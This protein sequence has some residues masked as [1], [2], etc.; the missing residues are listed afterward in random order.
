MTANRLIL[1]RLAVAA[2]A[3]VAATQA[4]ASAQYRF[5][6]SPAKL[7]ANE[8]VDWA[9]FGPTGTVVPSG[10]TLLSSGGLDVEVDFSANRSGRRLFQGDGW[11]GNFESSEPVLW[12]QGNGPL[13]LWFDG[14]G[15]RP[16]F[17]VG[18][19]FQSNYF[20]PFEALFELL[21]IHG[22]VVFGQTFLGNSTA[23]GDGSA[24]FAGG[25]SALGNIYG[26]RFTGLSAVSSPNDF[27][28]D[29][30]ALRTVNG[31]S[32]PEPAEWAAFGLLA[33]G[34]ATLMVRSRRR[35]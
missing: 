24:V 21:D 16:V 2:L 6:D 8:I 31:L 34:M 10:T 29:S 11:T 26:V 19:Q 7:G 27:A 4:P 12:T 9:D 17:G 33:S 28:V 3:G 35:R 30:V 1:V 5:V 22:N 25:T 14:H 32:V 18:A 13:T 15:R 20:G 23:M